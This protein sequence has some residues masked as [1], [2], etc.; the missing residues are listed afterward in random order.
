MQRV[1]IARNSTSTVVVDFKA[2]DGTAINLA[3]KTATFV[4]S[5]LSISVVGAVADAAT[6]RATFTVPATSSV[7][8]LSLYDAQILLTDTAPVELVAIGQADG[9]SGSIPNTVV[10]VT[11]SVANVA[12]I[13]V[14]ESASTPVADSYVGQVESPAI[15]NY[16]ID[17]AAVAARSITSIHLQTT[18]GT[19][20]VSIKRFRGFVQ[21][22]IATASVSS[23]ATNITSGI[24]PADLAIA[25]ELRLAVTAVNGAENL[26]FAI[27]YTQ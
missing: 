2:A 9:D 10:S 13:G 16:Y 25:D 3:A 4:V 27:G 20:D 17:P 23:T 18:A 24:D 21:S 7:A 14:F 6:G 15:T 5:S 22:T 26:Q 1:T 11:N 8:D 12:G 19:C